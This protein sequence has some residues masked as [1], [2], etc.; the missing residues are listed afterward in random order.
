MLLSNH[1]PSQVHSL[2]RITVNMKRIDLFDKHT[3]LF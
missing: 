1:R 3:L 2:I